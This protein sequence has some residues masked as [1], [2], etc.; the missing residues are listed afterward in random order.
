VSWETPFIPA[1]KI[2]K[3]KLVLIHGSW[4]F[5]PNLKDNILPD[6]MAST[7]QIAHLAKRYTLVEGD[8]YRCGANGV[9]MWCI[10]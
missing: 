7:D 3:L 8:L 9:L 4:R 1:R 10:T 6:D 2:Q 5:G